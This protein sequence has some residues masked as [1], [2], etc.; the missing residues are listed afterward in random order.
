MIIKNS[1]IPHSSFMSVDKDLELIVSWMQKDKNLCKLLYYSTKDA[2][3]K[4]ALTGAQLN[5]LLGRHI[6]IVPK[7]Y[8]DGSVLS[9]IIISMDNFIPSSNPEFRDNSIT[10]DIICHFDQ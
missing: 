7:L 4:P 9:Y 5:E 3:D 6:K 10:F 1:L 8:V 2:L